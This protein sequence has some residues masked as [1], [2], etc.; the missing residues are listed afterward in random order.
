MNAAERFQHWQSV[1]RGLIEAL[2]KLSDEQLEFV[3]R[4]GLWSLGKVVRHIA[5]AEDGWFRYVTTHEL[6]EW[7]QFPD[8]DYPT[9]ESVKKLLNEVHHRTEAYLAT[10]DDT[11]LEQSIL[12][13]WGSRFPLRW[14]IWHVLE[15]EISHRGEIYLMLGL[16]GMEA[17]DV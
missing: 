17:P 8:E 2:D 3:P 12:A 7:P 6:D 14:I 11:D 5:D 15:H 13:P 1:R 9:V 4:A 16:M 10:L